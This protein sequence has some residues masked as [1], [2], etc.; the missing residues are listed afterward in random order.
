MTKEE[1]IREIVER[2][3]RAWDTMD[4]DLLLSVFHHDMVWPWPP[5]AHSH[6][7]VDWVMEMGRF[8]HTRWRKTLME[9]FETHD[10]IHNNRE[11][12]KIVV[13]KQ[14]DA[15]FAVVDIDTL[16]R[17]KAHGHD[18]HWLGRACKMYTLV[19]GE[20]KM[21]AHTGLLDYNDLYK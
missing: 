20:W 17:G 9:L 14:G 6:D 18:F 12:R 1:E 2:E 19:G 7:P 5:S 4:A 16:W 11:I 3:T 21:I 8:D 10:L 13:S 15:A